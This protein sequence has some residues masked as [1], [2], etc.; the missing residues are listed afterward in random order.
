MIFGTKRESRIVKFTNCGTVFSI[1][2]SNW[3]QKFLKSPF[4]GNFYEISIF[5]SQNPII[6]SIMKLLSSYLL[7]ITF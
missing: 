2:T 3:V 1:K 6:R 5:E 7:Q 4:L